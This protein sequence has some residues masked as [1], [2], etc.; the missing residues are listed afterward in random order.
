[1]SSVRKPAVQDEKKQP[2]QKARLQVDIKAAEQG[3]HNNTNQQH[4]R[5]D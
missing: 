4:R 2:E 3:K 1:M 5:T